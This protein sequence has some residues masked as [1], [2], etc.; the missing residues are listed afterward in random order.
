MDFSPSL[1]SWTTLF[2]LAAAQGIFLALVLF[3][4]RPGPRRANWWLAGF[5]LCYSITLIDYVGFWSG[6]HYYFPHLAGI[7][8]PLAFLF[9]PL[10]YLYVRRLT[11]PSSE[12]RLKWLH[13]IPSFIILCW[14]LPFFLLPAA[15]KQEW[16]SGG[17]EQMYEQPPALLSVTNLI[18][19]LIIGQLVF[20]GFKIK[21]CIQKNDRQKPGNSFD[22]NHLLQNWSRS[23]YMLYLG[24]V[25]GYV[26]YY[27]LLNTPYFD[28]FQDYTIAIAM[29]I[30]IYGIGYTGYARPRVLSS[31]PTPPA[32]RESKYRHSTLTPGASQSMA[33]KLLEH[34]ELRRPYLNNE[35]RLADLAGQLGVSKHHLSQVINEQ[36]GKHFS[37]FVN[38]YR[39][40]EAQKMLRD[41]DKIAWPVIEIAYAAGFNNKTSFYQAFK[42]GTG[43]SPTTYRRRTR[44]KTT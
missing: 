8:L 26:A 37:E 36:L 7:Y 4:A 2:L 31:E 22:R 40:Q 21:Q 1:D 13:F 33:D 28:I 14:R 11:F 23:L 17:V 43:C 18:G 19:V 42:A 9:G 41:P 39:V 6:Y 34:M 12:F 32:H 25:A 5:L 24:Y 10:L 44:Q 20:Y 3:V 27:L 29:S 30:C 38:D 16:F 15:T 35:L